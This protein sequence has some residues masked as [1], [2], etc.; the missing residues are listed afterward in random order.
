MTEGLKGYESCWRSGW[1]FET[2]A[3]S[4]NKD[5]QPVVSNTI[6]FLL[7]VPGISSDRLDPYHGTE[8]QTLTLTISYW[9]GLS[10]DNLLN[11]LF[12]RKILHLI[13]S[14]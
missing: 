4:L 1:T 7:Y 14:D 5:I 11:S 12:H 10:S 8:N 2:G 6:V 9:K 13:I 3:V